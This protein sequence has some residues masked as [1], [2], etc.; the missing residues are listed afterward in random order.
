MNQDQAANL[1]HSVQK[2]AQYATFYLGSDFFGVEISSVQEILRA[3]ELTPA[4]LAPDY[5][6]GL[7]N[8]RGQIVTALDLSIRL[9]GR[10]EPASRQSM[11]VVVKTS[12]GMVSLLIDKI[13]DVLQVDESLMEPVPSTLQS[14]RR[15]YLKGVCKLDE[16]LLMILD[17]Q[18]LLDG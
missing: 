14:I 16:A 8:L 18:R 12:D 2:Q 4:P 13:G 5:V 9:L 11:N 7:I 17:L 6:S 10:R 15:E 3:Q 1:D